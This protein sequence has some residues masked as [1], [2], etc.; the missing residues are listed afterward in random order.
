MTRRTMWRE[1]ATTKPRKPQA[2]SREIIKPEPWDPESGR[3]EPKQHKYF[4][5]H[6]KPL[7]NERN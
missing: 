3:P 1:A 5:R 6:L 7:N 4:I 2:A